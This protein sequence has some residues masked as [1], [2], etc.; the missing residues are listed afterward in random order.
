[1]VKFDAYFDDLTSCSLIGFLEHKLPTNKSKAYSLYK[2]TL[3]S[4]VTDANIK[5]DRRV[6]AHACMEAFKEQ[7]K[8]E[9]VKQYWKKREL[10]NEIYIEETRH[11]L[12]ATRDTRNQGHLLRKIITGKLEKRNASQVEEADFEY[13]NKMKRARLER[14]QTPENQTHPSFLPSKNQITTTALY[15]QN[16]DIWVKWAQQQEQIQKISDDKEQFSEFDDD[17]YNFIDHEELKN[18]SLDNALIRIALLETL[19]QYQ[20]KDLELGKTIMN[21]NFLNEIID[22]TDASV[23]QCI[24]SKLN[25]G[26]QLWLNRILEKQ[27]WDQTSEFKD[28]C[29]QFTEDNCDRAQVPSFVRK[30]FVMG[31]FDPFLHEGHDIA[32]RIMTH[33]SERLEAPTNSESNASSLERTFSIDTSIFIMNRL[34]RMHHDVLDWNWM[35]ILTAVTRNRKIDGVL[36][37]LKVKKENHRVIGIVEFSK[38]IKSPDSKD[39]DDKV[40]LGRNAMRILNKLLDTVPFEKARVYTIQC[41]N[42]EIRIRYMVRP[43]PSIYLYDE[44]ARIKL[45]NSFDDMEQFATNM[46]ILMNFQ[47]DVLKTIKSIKKSTGDKKVYKSEVKPTPEGTK[48]NKNNQNGN[49]SDLVSSSVK[50]SASQQQD[51]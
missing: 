9:A 2:G 5:E 51:M 31:R 20:S 15:E 3:S 50:D 24:L 10:E 37:V 44:F 47:K 17:D 1:M 14:H 36:K 21:S 7:S 28:F 42:G 8:S 26:Q 12:D 34:F 19:F 45:P 40:K 29:S 27:T 35:E 11:V 30:S 16:N 48:K 13:Q 46:A 43:L 38:G 33:F 4:I 39:V 41:V 25:E 18:L 6:I 32:Q 22:I 23:K 49:Q